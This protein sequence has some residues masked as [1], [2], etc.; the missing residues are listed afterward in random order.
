MR[1]ALKGTKV[2]FERSLDSAGWS[3]HVFAVHEESVEH[4]G[5]VGGQED[6]RQP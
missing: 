1:V 2:Y 4:G 5:G 6:I 3:P